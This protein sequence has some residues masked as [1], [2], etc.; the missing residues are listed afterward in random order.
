[1][2][3]FQ[4]A[5]GLTVDG[6]VGRATWAALDKVPD[7]KP[8]TWTVHIPGLDKATAEAFAAA[9]DGAYITQEGE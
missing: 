2:K 4:A 9:Y 1:M 3:S 5:H 7:E 8:D 6:I